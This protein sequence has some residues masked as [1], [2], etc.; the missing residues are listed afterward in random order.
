MSIA[1]IPD[2]ITISADDADVRLGVL[3]MLLRH[4]E[5]DVIAVR[6]LDQP[7]GVDLY[8]LPRRPDQLTD[9]LY[10][11]AHVDNGAPLPDVPFPVIAYDRITA[12]HLY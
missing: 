4:A 1:I 6:T 11:T 9:H 10:G 8:V 5:G 3:R 2:A 7:D 12:L